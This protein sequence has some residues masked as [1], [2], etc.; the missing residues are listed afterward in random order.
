[1]VLMGISQG[2]Y[3]GKKLVI[4]GTPAL[5]APDPLSG[6]LGTS[7]TVIGS[8]L[9]DEQGSSQLLLNGA[10]I[11]VTAWSDSSI[12]FTVLVDDPATG[13]AWASLP[14]AVPFAVSKTGQLS[15]S[16]T[17]KVIT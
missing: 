13:V 4:F 8:G 6:K 1:M 3:L 5:F 12:Q 7:I 14:K 11:A 16:A 17:F 10:P 15:S 2:G 9:G